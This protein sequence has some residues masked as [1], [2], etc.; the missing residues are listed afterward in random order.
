MSV[1]LKRTVNSDHIL[2]LPTREEINFQSHLTLNMMTCYIMYQAHTSTHCGPIFYFCSD[3]PNFWN[4]SYK[5]IGKRFSVCFHWFSLRFQE[6]TY[7]KKLKFPSGFFCSYSL[8]GETRSL[9]FFP[10]VISPKQR[11][12]LR[13]KIHRN[14]FLSFISF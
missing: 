2:T 6:I 5:L 9:L 8:E 7:A 1:L 13:A 4:V 3:L 14:V 11:E 10:Y 12:N